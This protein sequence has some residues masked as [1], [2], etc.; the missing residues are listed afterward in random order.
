V[1][2][3]NWDDQLR[4]LI[5]QTGMPLAR[6]AEASGR[7][8]ESILDW[9]NGAGESLDY[10]NMNSLSQYLGVSIE[11]LMYGRC[12]TQLVRQRIFSGPQSLP[13]AFAKNASSF[14]RTSAHIVDYLS[15]MYGRHFVDRIL[16][17]LNIHPLIFDDL[18][19]RINLSFFITFLNELS[20]QGMTDGEITSLACYLFLRIQNTPIGNKFAAA[21]TYE[22]SYLVL[23][24]DVTHFESNFE[25]KFEID[26]Q[27]I[28]I[29]A[30]PTEAQLF[31]TS[32]QPQ[33][34]GRLFAY[35]R[36]AFGWFPLL[37]RLAPLNLRMSKCVLRGDRE[38]IY[39][40]DFPASESFLGPH[41]RLI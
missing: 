4:Q 41:L 18:D 24:N 14:T 5:R 10:S 16:L 29:I 32:L 39:E 38:T 17:N 30:K 37:S 1:N 7:K 21:K 9:W 22:E 36:K 15:M 6:F 8:N 33:A 27:R 19:N 3:M 25:Y 34:Y 35:R 28:R 20:R 2:E 40:A 31:L 12:S 26:P 23:M 11:D 13:E